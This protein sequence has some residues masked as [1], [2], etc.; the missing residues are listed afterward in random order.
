MESKS[1]LVKKEISPHGAVPTERQIE[2]HKNQ[3]ISIVHFSINT[4][5]D[6]EWGY[7][8]ESPKLF[9]PSEFDAGQWAAVCKETGIKG[10]VMVAKHHDGFCLWPTKTTEHCIRNSSWKNGSGDIVGE[11]AEACRKYGLKFGV[12]CSP[13]DRNNAE[14][15]KPGYVDV[16]HEQ[17][18]ELL[19]GYGP[20]FEVWFD[21]ANGGDGYYGGAYDRRSIS[22]DYYKWDTVTNMI[23]Q[24]QPGACVFG[25]NDIRFI[26]NE[27]GLADKTC[28]STVFQN[29]F[30]EQ[31]KKNLGCGERGGKFW[32]PGECDFPLRTGWFYHKDDR[33]KNAEALLDIYLK[34]CGHGCVMNIGLAP[35]RRGLIAE[36]DIRS[37]R[38]WKKLMD[39]IF[40]CNLLDENVKSVTSA[41]RT[42]SDSFDYLPENVLLE[43]DSFWIADDDSGKAELV[44]ELKKKTTFNLIE[45]GEFIELGQRVDEFAVD[46]MCDGKWVEIGNSTSIGFKR[47]LMLKQTTTDK[48]RIR[49]TRFSAQPVIRLIRLF[50]APL[51]LVMNSKISITRDKSGLVSITGNSDTLELHYT[52]DGSDPDHNSP[53]YT[54]PFQLSGGGLVKAVGVIAAENN[55]KT[56]T[57]EAFFGCDRG[58]WRVLEVSLDS[59][60]DNDGAAGKD[61]LLDDDSKTYWHTYH[62]DKNLSAPPHYVI[63]DMSEELELEALTFMPR[64]V[65]GGE[66]SGTPDK[67]EFYLSR[68]NKDWNKVAE[69]EF[70]NIAANPG[71]QTV[72]LKEPVLARYIKF[73]A[74]H[75]VNDESYVIVSGIGAIKKQQ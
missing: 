28:W 21:G 33:T 11:V 69:G 7:G 48:L 42:Q 20:L 68:N 25:I 40:A 75:T 12:Y 50:K 6:K 34:S 43:D 52:T 14:Y 62:K 13:W 8:D 59:P 51:S 61:H 41:S 72:H 63:L 37:L 47:L 35:D 1:M 30:G 9:N 24:H 56:P 46:A 10:I 2:W 70:G 67:Y 32:L 26:G 60:F 53:R 5:A 65:P 38:D 15:G 57:E 31:N 54:G 29:G 4:F 23:R 73:V 19:T 3:V 45:I 58:K 74:L 44:I 64:S 18:R 71:M 55:A 49:F 36:E 39:D 66:M 16:F 22:S 17:L 27:H